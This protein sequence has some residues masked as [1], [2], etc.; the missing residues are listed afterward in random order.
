[1]AEE[2]DA[3][4]HSSG[5]PQAP[6]AQPETAVQNSEPAA[7]ATQAQVEHL[8]T[9]AAVLVAF[10][11][12]L[13]LGAVLFLL[14]A[15]GVFEPKQ[16]LVLVADDADGVAPGMD[17]IF[18]GFPIGRVR[19]VDLTDKGTVRISVEVRKEDAR[20]LRTSSVFTLVR[21]LVG[22]AQLRAYS[23]VMTDPPL[24]EGAERPVLRGDANAEIQRVIGAAR[25]VLDNLNEITGQSSE[26]NRTIANLQAFS[27][28]LQ[29]KQGALHAVFGNEQDAR[30]LVQAIENANAVMTRVERFTANADRRVFGADGLA[31]DAQASVRQF[32]ALL[33][34]ARASM[35]RVDAVL[36]EAQAVGSNLRSGTADLGSLRSEVE[37]NLRKIEDMINDLNR[38]FPFAKERK[39]ELP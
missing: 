2:P 18:S 32:N 31:S 4:S 13:V 15:R 24:P 30:K 17:L 16:A 33:A 20:L 3:S 27:L 28:K 26:L 14:H 19:Q 29:G 5:P 6:P 1:M 21:G 35:K 37:A 25:D 7:K 22:A 39:I 12:V 34:D 36:A 38:K 11:L 23:G 8:E 10:T 9:K